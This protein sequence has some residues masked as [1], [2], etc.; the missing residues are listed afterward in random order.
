MPTLPVELNA[1]GVYSVQAPAEFSTTEPFTVE[2]RNRG[3]PVHVHLNVDDE[4]ARVASLTA[5][6]HYVDA[7]SITR[8]RVDTR[9]PERAT[10]GKLKIAAG[11]GTE[12]HYVDVEVQPIPE[13]EEPVVVDEELSKPA[14]PEPEESSPSPVES[15]A[16]AL[17]DRS[18]LPQ[19][20]AA[21]AF[22]ALAVAAAIL[23]GVLVRSTVVTVGVLV[24][25]V[26]AAGAVAVL[27]SDSRSG[28][29]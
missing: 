19:I 16:G 9:E 1:D 13:V 22:V 26:A 10:G 8:V 25:I 27:Q 5:T 11:H 18:E 15:V 28:S 24:V 2:L 12:T 21:H 14:D 20:T 6:S 17:P 4:L 3:Q 7:D 29:P 23:V